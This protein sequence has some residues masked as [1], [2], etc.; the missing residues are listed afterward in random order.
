LIYKYDHGST[1]TMSKRPFEGMF[2]DTP[3]VRL[4][5]HFLSLPR[6]TF[7][8][9]ELLE[10]V[11]ISRPTLMDK[12]AKFVGLE[13]ISEVRSVRPM[14]FQLNSDSDLVRAVNIV[15]F[16]L[17][18]QIVPG[19]D[20]YGTGIMKALPREQAIEL[21]NLPRRDGK[22][23]PTVRILLDQQTARTLTE[24]LEDAARNG[25]VDTE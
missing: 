2:G 12:L 21:E 1:D 25:S 16:A 23:R 18:D 9:K 3:E 20:Y 6:A 4:L 15:N 22:E 13:V 10:H 5:E 8:V 19:H 7:T 24:I 17:I 11:D 14:V